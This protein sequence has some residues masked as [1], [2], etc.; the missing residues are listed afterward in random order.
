[1]IQYRLA[2]NADNQ[3]L[4]QLTSASGMTGEIA[5]RIDRKP[6]F[7][8]LL[9][10]R[11]ESK[12]FVAVDEN[13]IVGSICVSR[14]EVYVDGQIYPLQYFA[15]FKISEPYRNKTIGYRL[16]KELE[17]YVLE[18]GADLAFINYAKGNTKPTRFFFNRQN[19][20]DFENI[21]IFNIHQFIGKKKKAF[22][23][24]YKI[25]SSQIS[26]ELIK[27][28][29]AH[30]SKFELGSV[31][32]KEKLEGSIIFTIQENE[33]IIAA[34]CLLDTMG[35]KQ[36]VVTGVSWKMKYLL[37]I[38]NVLNRLFGLSKM[39][40]INEPVSMI[41]I[42]YLVVNNNEKQL[43]RFLID[44]ARNIAYEKSYS[45]VSVGVHEKD[46]L[47]T[48]FSGLFK[49]TFSSVGMVLSLKNNQE[50]IEKVKRGIPFA[51]YSIV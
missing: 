43:V 33:K 5:L 19:T 20:P 24:K 16:C 36:N 50:L 3:Q 1:M 49:M 40:K 17:N 9:N 34:L 15:D 32:T 35:I 30:Y 48:C 47:N 45:F 12:V 42:K 51:D 8:K 21:G 22:H 39:P 28:L 27:F 38:L 11:G 29:N 10:M 18:I 4:I 2:T 41:Y 13:L 31:V 46:Q 23:P 37:K 26:E 25:K 44:H 6:D 14:E 7:F